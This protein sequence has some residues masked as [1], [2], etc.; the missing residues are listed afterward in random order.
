MGR[1]DR[2]DQVHVLAATRT[3]V[4]GHD[5]CIRSP[6]V[7]DE[8]PAEQGPADVVV[9]L[10]GSG[11]PAAR[12]GHAQVGHHSDAGGLLAHR[13]DVPLDQGRM[14]GEVG[15]VEHP[16][17]AGQP[18]FA[19]TGQKYEHR[20]PGVVDHGQALQ[21]VG[22]GD[23]GVVEEPDDLIDTGALGCVMVHDGRSVRCRGGRFP[24]AAPGSGLDVGGISARYAP[25]EVI[26]S[27]DRG[28]H[29]LVVHVAADGARLGLHRGDIEAH[30][31]EDPQVGV[32][33]DLVGR[34]HGVLV[35]VERVAVAHDELAGAQQSEPG[36]GLVAKL[37]LNLIHGERQLAVGVDL[38][39]D[40][41]R[42]DLFVGRPEHE[43]SA[44]AF[45]G[46]GR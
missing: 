45:D 39:S 2:T 7:D 13:S 4:P 46:H 9:R 17:P 1:F 36:P 12:T 19:V 10:V 32:V 6:L 22:G 44:P 40:S 34:L 24:E 38:G 14:C 29:E 27:Y 37:D 33:D 18:G 43:R 15:I 41:D 35:D 28:D 23:R 16:P 30:P 11:D 8:V 3:G 20:T 31:G 25:D 5:L 42:H 21:E 26:L